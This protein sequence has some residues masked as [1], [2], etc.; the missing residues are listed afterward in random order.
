MKSKSQDIPVIIPRKVLMEGNWVRLGLAGFAFT[1][2]ICNFDSKTYAH[3][4]CPR[5]AED[6]TL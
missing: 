3:N 4:H 5:K 1:F 6:E 2:Q